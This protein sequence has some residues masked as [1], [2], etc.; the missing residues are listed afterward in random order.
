MDPFEVEITSSLLGKK[1]RTK[2]AA[3]AASADQFG[4]MTKA[5]IPKLEREVSAPVVIN[6]GP[7]TKFANSDQTPEALQKQLETEKVAK[8]MG[9]SYV[10]AQK[11]LSGLSA[12]EK[13]IQFG[14]QPKTTADVANLE[15]ESKKI[16][17]MQPATFWLVL[18]GLFL[19]TITIIAVTRKTPAV[20][21][22]K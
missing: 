8:K 14:I 22:T 6:T 2:N 1:K 4:A 15:E 3:D 13:L 7:L 19:T 20:A 18:G 5:S 9:L 11:L 17:G 16:L 10:N 21:V 12:A